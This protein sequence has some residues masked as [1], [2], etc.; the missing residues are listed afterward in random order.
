MSESQ[1]ALFNLPKPPRRA[2]HENAMRKT[3]REACED[4]I[5]RAAKH[6]EDVS[7]GWYRKAVEHVRQYALYHSEFMC[8]AVRARAESQ[9]FPKPPDKRAWGN[10]MRMAGRQ[11]FVRKKGISY[12][13]DPKVH[14][15]PAGLWK[16]LIC[17][18]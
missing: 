12:A 6:A 9:K 7:P 13:T 11:R 14:M 17:H 10:V 2:R 3:A 18:S 15:N 16:S 5:K 4:G 8:E 1:L